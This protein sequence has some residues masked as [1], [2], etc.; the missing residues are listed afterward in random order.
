MH[1]TMQTDSQV[2]IKIRGL[3]AAELLNYLIPGTI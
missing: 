1:G 2:L 3:I